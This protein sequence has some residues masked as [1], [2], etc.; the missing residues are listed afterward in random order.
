MSF[1][2]TKIALSET[3]NVHQ[4]AWNRNRYYVNKTSKQADWP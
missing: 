2:G 3:V 1:N 4:G